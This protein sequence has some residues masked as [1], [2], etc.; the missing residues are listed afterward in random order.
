[1]NEATLKKINEELSTDLI[2]QKFGKVFTLSRFETAIDF[3][4]PDSCFLFV[5]IN[6]V[7]PRIYFINRRFKD[8][9]KNSGNPPPFVLMV[10][11]RLSN[12]VLNKIEKVENERILQFFFT[13]QTEF[14]ETENYVFVVQL[15]GRS[16]NLYLLNEKNIILD[17]LRENTGNGQEIGDFYSP[18]AR[19]D[20]FKKSEK[21]EEVFPKGGFET[22]S[23]ALDDFFLTREAEQRF[24]SIANSAE[25]KLNAELKKRGKLLKNLKRDLQRHG[26]AETWKRCGDLLLANVANA[27]R[28]GETILVT[29]YYDEN[30]P[31]VEI[32]ADENLSV[33]EVAENYFKRYTK[34][35][36]AGEE[37]TKRL[38][39][40]EKE[41]EKLKIKKE[42]LKKAF[43]EKDED[44]FEQFKEDKKESGKSKKKTKQHAS[45]SRSF[46][47]SDGFEILV[48]KGAKDNDLLTFRVA[49]SYDMWLH[50]ADYPGSHTI[51]KN[52]NRAEIPPKTLVEAAQLAAFYSQAKS[53][54]KAAV[55]YTQRKFVHKPKGGV[56]GL[57]NLSSFKTI[58]VEPRFLEGEKGRKGEGE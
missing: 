57:V 40:L 26:D 56:A 45:K 39:V 22:V 25:S 49:K 37:I 23:E 54:P 10:R 52:P 19:P 47:S 24:K 51:I 8:L 7:S 53:Q 11:K 46:T 34:A 43:E 50:A 44:F 55:H 33:T 27:I 35:R 15:T 5:S 20:N 58:L 18:P 17:S 4:L 36:N 1:M 30:L 13:V 14:G 48:G 3:R 29:D 42:K 12:A 38:A 21:K 31:T 16:S 9:E 6:P 28:E 32:K 2:G 41:T